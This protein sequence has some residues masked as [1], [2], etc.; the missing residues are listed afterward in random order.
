MWNKQ[1]GLGKAAQNFPDISHK[2]KHRSVFV[3]FDNLQVGSIYGPAEKPDTEWINEIFRS[4]C[5]QE[6][7]HQVF[8]GDYNWKPTYN[9]SVPRTW[10]LSSSQATTFKDTAPTRGVSSVPL[11]QVHASA[12]PGVRTHLAV[13]F[14]VEVSVSEADTNQARRLRRCAIYEWQ[15]EWL[16]PQQL[17]DLLRD[18]D[19][20]YPKA[21]AS[22]PLDFR[23]DNWHQRTECA[24]QKAV[25]FGFAKLVRKAE[26]AKG[27][28]P[29]SRCCGQA[30]KHREQ[31]T[32]IHRR[33]L[34]VHRSIS[35]RCRQGESFQTALSG[36]LLE[37]TCRVIHDAS[38]YPSVSFTFGSALTALND[39]ILIEEKTLRQRTAK[40]WR[41][42]FRTFTKDIWGPAKSVLKNHKI[43]AAFNANDMREEWAKHWCPPDTFKAREAVINCAKFA[44]DSN[45][46]PHI[47][48]SNS[49]PD[50]KDFWE[51]L[52]SASGAAG[53]DGWTANEIKAIQHHM[54]PLAEELF[55]LWLD[56][57][58]SSDKELPQSLLGKIWNW[59]VVGITKKTSFDSR[60][61]SIAS[62][63]VRSWHKALFKKCPAMPAGQW[64]GKA[65]TSVVDATANFVAARPKLVAE[66]DLT[67][68]FD[69]LWTS[70]AEHAMIHAGV[71]PVIAK[72][73]HRAWLGPRTCTVG[74]LLATEINPVR[75]VPQG[76]PCSPLAL[77]ACLGVWTKLVEIIH[78]CLKTWAY[79]DDRTIAV[80]RHG[81][82]HHLESAL[83]ATKDFDKKVG[84]QINPEK[85][86]IWIK[87]ESSSPIEHLGLTF[88]PAR[89]EA[90]LGVRDPKKKKKQL[91]DF[92]DVRVPLMLELN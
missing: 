24:F 16:E 23:W 27:S 19:I 90:P 20:T 42:H 3:S 84:F 45:Y 43:P 85:T 40:D 18:V 11:E 88:D 83:E 57:S 39:L 26:R 22:S 49:L 79:M 69:H 41:A 15:K 36:T 50:R 35:E 67:K 48:P 89:P 5:T 21:S 51:A 54:T 62:L 63:L 38:G 4:S 60:P 33:L 80:V 17:K 25:K 14:K 55:Q 73:L 52:N 46:K 77:A 34:R 58:N 44:S 12:L 66:T 30:A 53:F 70:L 91:K 74:G 75:G 81:T 13:T 10:F 7:K 72:T 6:D 8:I 86:Q 2:H 87:N 61:I 29:T 59:K 68:A 64:C 1:A 37:K 56:T 78:P 65:K 82:K 76:D 32:V 47:A 71:P 9:K 92:I 31:Q 28:I